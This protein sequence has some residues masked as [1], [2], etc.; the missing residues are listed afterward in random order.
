[1][2]ILLFYFDIILFLFVYLLSYFNI[3]DCNLF[4]FILVSTIHRNFFNNFLCQSFIFVLL[5]LQS[6]FSSSLYILSFDHFIF[7]I[8]FIHS[9]L[10]FFPFLPFPFLSCSIISSYK[11]VCIIIK[12]CH[13]SIYGRTM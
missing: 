9:F 5:L 8:L 7:N 13:E 11:C 1:M 2:K 4:Y 3:N 12:E 6:C 10:T